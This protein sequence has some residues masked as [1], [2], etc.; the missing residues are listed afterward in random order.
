MDVTKIVQ[1]RL[2]KSEFKKDIISE[3][4]KI[5]YLTKDNYTKYWDD[6]KV[7][8][9]LLHN[10]LEWDGI[11]DENQIEK[12]FKN[13]SELFL[14]YYNDKVVGWTWF[15]KYFTIDWETNLQSLGDNE[16]YVGAAFISK[17]VNLPPEAGWKFYNQSFNKWL[18]DLKKEVIY[19]Y[20]DDWNRA[21]AQLCY[22]CGFTKFNFIK[23]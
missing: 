10:D 16:L 6:I 21:S 15:N 7:V 23:K 1:F 5:L 14:W 17:K 13:N 12:R 9:Q 2:L 22:R 19:L 20:S 11:P 18:T 3:S 4:Y 8:I